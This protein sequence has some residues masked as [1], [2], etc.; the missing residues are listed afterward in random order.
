MSCQ[1][2]PGAG[3]GAGKM[4]AALEE[5]LKRSGD[6]I[7]KRWGDAKSS[8]VSQMRDAL[9]SAQVRGSRG[10]GWGAGGPHPAA[11]RSEQVLSFAGAKTEAGQQAMEEAGQ[12]AIG[13]L[14]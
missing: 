12:Q 1:F 2:N 8:L 10:Q 7:L 13:G 4:F 3:Y 14:P 6:G 11:G 9:C 5:K